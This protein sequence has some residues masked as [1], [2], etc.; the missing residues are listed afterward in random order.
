MLSLS[1]FGNGVEDYLNDLLGAERIA[2]DLPNGIKYVPVAIFDE[3]M[4][5]RMITETAMSPK[6]IKEIRFVMYMGVPS[7][8]DPEGS[9]LTMVLVSRRGLILLRNRLLKSVSMV[10]VLTRPVSR[11]GVLYHRCVPW[12]RSI[13]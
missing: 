8:S 2:K 13:P 10:F 11:F 7:S 4:Y 3:K 9:R 1:R 12:I 6:S 5:P